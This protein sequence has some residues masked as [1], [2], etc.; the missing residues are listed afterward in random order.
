MASSY[1]LAIEGREAM[2]GA[3]LPPPFIVATVAARHYHQ[4]R[5]R[6]E[7]KV[8]LRERRE[9]DMEIDR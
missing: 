6:G 4:H 1:C 2:P 8:C 7:N 3:S 5:E 9:G